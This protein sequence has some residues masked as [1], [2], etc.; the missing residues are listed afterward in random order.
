MANYGSNSVNVM[1][2][3]SGGTP[4]DI[5]TYCKTI[6]GITI[7]ALLADLTSFG[8]IWAVMAG[9][10][11]KKMADI[12]IGGYYDDV[13]LGP[14]AVFV[15][16]GGGTRTLALTYGS[17]KKT[18]VEVIIKKYDRMPLLNDLTKYQVTLTPTGV[19][20]EA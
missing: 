6:N 5:T 10:G 1:F 15:G 7:E 9:V 13:A 8:M 2:D 14:D 19:P 11:T 3:D 18:T 16:I 20:T 17:T 12:V 4:R